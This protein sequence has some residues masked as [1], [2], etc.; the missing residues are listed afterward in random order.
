VA[1]WAVALGVFMILVASASSRAASTGGAGLPGS[2][3]PNGGAALPAPDAETGLPKGTSPSEVLARM[4]V[5]RA[6]WYGPGLYGRRTACGIR[7]GRSTAGVAHRKLPCGALV[8]FRYRG[9]FTTVPVIDRGPFARR[10]SWDLTA[11]PGMA[12]RGDSLS[13]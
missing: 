8:T 13:R 9:R 12:E 4:S 2:A 3:G 1:A 7:L 11:R 5:G 10:V 6:S